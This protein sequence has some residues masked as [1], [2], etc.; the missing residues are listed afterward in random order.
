MQIRHWIVKQIKLKKRSLCDTP[1]GCRSNT[2]ATENNTDKFLYQHWQQKKNPLI[3]IVGIIAQSR[4]SVILLRSQQDI[5]LIGQGFS[6]VSWQRF[7]VLSC[8]SFGTRIN[9]AF[10]RDHLISLKSSIKEGVQQ[11][12]LLLGK[13]QGNY[14]WSIK[15]TLFFPNCSRPADIS[16]MSLPGQTYK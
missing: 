4:Q 11:G 5:K 2:K 3:C 8:W 14:I 12:V 16:L 7:I 9:G 10:G 1:C 13:S 15:G 6:L